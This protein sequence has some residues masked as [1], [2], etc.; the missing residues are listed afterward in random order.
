MQHSPRTFV[1]G[2]VF[3]PCIQQRENFR[4]RRIPR[5]PAIPCRISRTTSMGGPRNPGSSPRGAAERT[6]RCRAYGDARYPCSQTA[7]SRLR[8]HCRLA[9]CCVPS[10]GSCAHCGGA[11]ECIWPCQ[12]SASKAGSGGGGAALGLAGAHISGKGE[13]AR[14][15]PA[16]PAPASESPSSST[17]GSGSKAH[18]SSSTANLTSWLRLGSAAVETGAMENRRVLGAGASSAEAYGDRAIEA[19]V[20]RD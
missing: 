19:A 14:M 2:H 6:W 18:P 20:A 8:L 15:P 7:A 17:P 12:P 13:G 9:R 1:V 10:A 4:R 11:A 5:F 16:A 3:V